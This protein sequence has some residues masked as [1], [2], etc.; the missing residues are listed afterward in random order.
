MDPRDRAPHDLP[1]A[2]DLQSNTLETVLLAVADL[3][4]RNTGAASASVTLISGDRPSTFV[5]TD[6][7]AMALDETQYEQ[8]YGPC[9]D[10]VLSRN[11]MEIRDTRTET[12]WPKFTPVAAEHG[13]LSMLSVPIPV[14]DGVA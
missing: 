8:G 7:L 2:L 14:V 13:A 12:R 3:A 10:A 4:V 5:S 6:E 11:V 9:L 1:P